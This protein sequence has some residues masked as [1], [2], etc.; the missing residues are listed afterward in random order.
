MIVASIVSADVV[1]ADANVSELFQGD[2]SPATASSSACA[3]TYCAPAGVLAKSSERACASARTRKVLFHIA[4][5]TLA[6][7]LTLALFPTTQ[8]SHAFFPSVYDLT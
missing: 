7:A 4:Q 3:R 2:H 5:Y 8:S 1:D 6:A